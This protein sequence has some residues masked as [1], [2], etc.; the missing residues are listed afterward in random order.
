MTIQPGSIAAQQGINWAL[1]DSDNGGIGITRPL[2]AYCGLHALSLMPEPG[3]TSTRRQS[4][5]IQSD[6]RE[7]VHRFVESIWQ[8]IDTWGIAG[9]G[10]YWKPIL[11]VQVEVGAEPQ[12]EQLQLLLSGSGIV[13]Q[14]R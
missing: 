7:T 4:V 2:Q 11:Q 14:Q 3:S 12:F 5:T 10:V 9:P 8:R 1:P 13:V 6:L